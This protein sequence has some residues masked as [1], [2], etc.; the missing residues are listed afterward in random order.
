MRKAKR[1]VILLLAAVL[2]AGCSREVTGAQKQY[3][4]TFLTLFDTVTTIVGRAESEEAFTE[5]AQSIHDA[6]LE[7]HRLFDIYNDYEGVNNLKTVNDNAG[8]APVTVDER[9]IRLLLDC[10]DYYELTGGMVNPAMG[11]V[12][13]LWH[14]ARNDGIDDPANAYL[15]DGEALKAAAE[16]MDFDS[17][18]I[19][20][21]A[22]TVY[23][24]DPEVQLDVGAI[25]K[26]WAVQ[27]VCETAPAGLLISVG[28]NV[29]ATGPKDDSGTPWVVGI[30]NPD[31]GD[32]YLHTLYVTSGSV[33]TS[34]DY[35]RAYMVDGKLY[36]HI[37]DPETLYPSAYWRSVTILCADSGL[38]DALSTALFL[39]PQEEGQA[40][41]DK[42]GAEAMW[43]ASDGSITY[44]PGF[45]ENIRT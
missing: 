32:Q 33:V 28:G 22:S 45:E 27:R 19:D 25:A 26:G 37:I 42:C 23:I 6:L 10:K 13:S 39:L 21:A 2:L 17:V 40:L 15:P 5:T 1:A 4:A 7:Y 35:Q 30:Q 31:G 29:C 12:L 8:L 11:S 16:H 20:E 36:H 9:I 43:V 38:A 24:S 34:G 14:E 44:S 3:N 18:V 41:L